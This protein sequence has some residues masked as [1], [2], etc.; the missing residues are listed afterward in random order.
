MKHN[1]FFFIIV[2]SKYVAFSKSGDQFRPESTIEAYIPI[3]YVHWDLLAENIRRNSGTESKSF[4]ATALQ[5][6]IYATNYNN[7]H[8][9]FSNSTL[10]ATFSSPYKRFGLLPIGKE[11]I[12]KIERTPSDLLKKIVAEVRDL[13]KLVESKKLFLKETLSK[14]FV[15]FIAKRIILSE[16]SPFFIT[17]HIIESEYE[18]LLIR[19]PNLPIVA[20][21]LNFILQ[22]MDGNGISGIKELLLDV[23]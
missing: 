3:Q 17:D 22:E 10:F 23:L 5:Y 11:M 7:I 13:A 9:R 14:E 1:F 16:D 18:N 15:P 4:P 6:G 20:L 8:S 19:L 12:E 21:V 2:I